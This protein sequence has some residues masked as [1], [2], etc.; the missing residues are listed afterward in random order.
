[1]PES[2]FSRSSVDHQSTLSGMLAQQRQTEIARTAER[3]R[4]VTVALETS[5]ARPGRRR[6]QAALTLARVQAGLWAA[7]PTLAGLVGRHTDR[8]TTSSTTQQLACCA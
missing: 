5:H 7:K 1:M 8:T 4:L 6:P 3:R 2:H